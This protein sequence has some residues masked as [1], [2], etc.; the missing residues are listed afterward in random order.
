MLRLMAEGQTNQEIGRRL[1]LSMSTI[2]THVEHIL[3]KLDV[4]DRT[5][6]AVRAAQLGLLACPAD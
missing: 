4:G 3:T 2:K 5:Q 6:A 1:T